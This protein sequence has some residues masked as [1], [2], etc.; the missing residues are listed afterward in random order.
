MLAWLSRARC[1]F[2]YGPADVTATHCL[3]LSKNQIGFTFLV[4]PHLGSPGKRAIKRMC[5]RVCVRACVFYHGSA[6]S[7]RSIFTVKMEA[8]S[9]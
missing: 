9:P 7:G 2:A 3:L 8:V 1:R 5:V 4:L 6:V